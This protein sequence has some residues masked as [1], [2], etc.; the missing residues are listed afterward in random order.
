MQLVPLVRTVKLSHANS[1]FWATTEGTCIR[2]IWLYHRLT[3]FIIVRK[4]QHSGKAPA[5]STGTVW[6]F[7]HLHM[8]T[9]VHRA[10]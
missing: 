8:F 6:K 2:V 4:T 7:A 10:R 1:C 3:V 5:T 9:R